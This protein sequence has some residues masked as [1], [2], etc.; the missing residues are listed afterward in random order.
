[1]ILALAAAAIISSSPISSGDSS[2][3]PLLEPVPFEADS[4]GRPALLDESARTELS[5]PDSE[6]IRAAIE[7]DDL[8]LALE[9]IRAELAGSP[10]EARRSRLLILEARVLDRMGEGWEATRV[11]R[12]ILADPELGDRARR[13]LHDLYIRRGQFR[14][15][16]RL[17]EPGPDGEMSD[18]DR[19]M[20]AYAR[21]VEGRYTEAARLA[22]PLATRGHGPAAVLRAN[23]LLALG[24]RD[25]AERLYLRVL[26]EQKDPKVRQ[27]AHFGLGQVARLR[28]GRAVRALQDEKAVELG[29]APWAE[30]DWGLALR[31]LGRREEARERLAAVARSAPEFGSTVHL[32]M[33]RLDEEEGRADDALEQLAAALDGSLGDFLAFARAGELLIQEGEEDQGI[34]AYRM[35]MELFPDFPPARD[36]LTRALAQRGRWEEAMQGTDN[37]D[38][39]WELPGWTW[40]R[41]LDG[42]LPFFPVSGDRDSLPLG[43]PRRTV[44]AFVHFRAGNAGA[45]LGWSEGAGPG[46]PVL[47]AVRAE[48]LEAVDRKD[49]AE[50]LWEAVLNSGAETPVGREHLARLVFERDPDL[51]IQRWDALFEN[52]PHRVR[53]R[54]RMARMLADAKLY[55]EALAAYRAVDES[56]WLTPKE[57]MRLRVERQDVEDLL[58]E[59][60][61]GGEPLSLGAE[62]GRA[63]Q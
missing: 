19:L 23:A 43:D 51:A 61:G 63:D 37:P 29:P 14:A 33:A 48:A 16:D 62:G 40:E 2:L 4:T 58:A 46:T 39:P 22:A 54:I 41:L 36:K 44:M 32:V 49:E 50:Q 60:E 45:A 47:A 31:A 1:V 15:A 30:L 11:Y 56:A 52:Y 27:V 21:S 38:D 28:G 17:T 9:R 59:M 26:D 13:E 5:S 34:E 10:A 8:P 6:G 12:R 3:E 42:D 24:D 18:R 7:A 57:Q 35:A 25:G 20:R 53:A 55:T